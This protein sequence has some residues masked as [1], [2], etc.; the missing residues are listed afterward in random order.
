MDDSPY[1]S[2]FSVAVSHHLF[3]SLKTIK[4]K[5]GQARPFLFPYMNL[6]FYQNALNL[7]RIAFHL[8][9]FRTFIKCS[10]CHRNAI[11]IAPST[12]AVQS[13]N[14]NPTREFLTFAFTRCLSALA[15]C[16]R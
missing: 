8:A 3:R 10:R 2:R 9:F 13:L 12:C 11:L 4:E 5:L 1:P 16:S 14:V 7:V 15:V 6:P